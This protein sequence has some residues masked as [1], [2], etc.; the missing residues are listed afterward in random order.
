VSRSALND[1]QAYIARQE[2]EHHQ[3]A[4]FQD[5]LREFLCRHGVEFDERFVWG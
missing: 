3:R 5:E 1:V 4:S 2:E